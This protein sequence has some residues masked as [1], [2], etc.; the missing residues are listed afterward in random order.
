MKGNPI[1]IYVYVHIREREEGRRDLILTV[2]HPEL[3]LSNI[4]DSLFFA[5]VRFFSDIKI[6][7][8]R[9]SCLISRIAHHRLI[10]HL[11]MNA[12]IVND[13]YQLNVKEPVHTMSLASVRYLS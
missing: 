7:Y 11:A 4:C 6:E 2:E 8:S 13:N 5:L 10:Q 9:S 1:Y 12:M 3:P